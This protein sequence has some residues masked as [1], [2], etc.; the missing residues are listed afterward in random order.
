LTVSDKIDI[1]FYPFEAQGNAITLAKGD[2][3]A[4]IMDGFHARSAE[5]KSGE[6][7][8]GWRAFVKEN[9]TRYVNAIFNPGKAE[10]ETQKNAFLQTFAHLLDCEAHTDMW[11]ELFPTWNLTNEK[12]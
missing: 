4:Q 3:Y 5:L 2:R 10:S 1:D 7:R 11:R 9:Q 6:W 8:N 12:E